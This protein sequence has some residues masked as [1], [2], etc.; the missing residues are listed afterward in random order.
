MPVKPEHLAGQ[1][2][3]ALHKMAERLRDELKA[4]DAQLA[5][6]RTKLDNQARGRDYRG[7][8]LTGNDL[9]G[10]AKAAE[11]W[12]ADLDLVLTEIGKRKG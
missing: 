12:R 3:R 5:D 11:M 6:Q 2:L 8:A 9:V 1:D 7:L 4:C 10:R